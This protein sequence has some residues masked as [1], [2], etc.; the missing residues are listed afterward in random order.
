MAEIGNEHGF[1][2]GALATIRKKPATWA[3]FV[4]MGLRAVP[5]DAES[6]WIFAPRRSSERGVDA[7]G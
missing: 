6:V 3:G 7:A 1:S 4:L 2:V 5:D